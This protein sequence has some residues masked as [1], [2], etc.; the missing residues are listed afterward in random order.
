MTAVCPHCREPSKY[1]YHEEHY[2]EKHE[3]TLH[4]QEARIVDL[5]VGTQRSQGG[6]RTIPPSFHFK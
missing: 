1:E 4:L 6:S 3:I 2:G 5:T